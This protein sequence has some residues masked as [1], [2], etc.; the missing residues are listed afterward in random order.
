MMVSPA[1]ARSTALWID[2][3][4]N[5]LIVAAKLIAGRPSRSRARPA[6]TEYFAPIDRIIAPLGFDMPAFLSPQ[7]AVRER[8]VDDI[9]RRCAPSS[10]SQHEY[11][12]DMRSISSN[13]YS[14]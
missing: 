4:G 7:S 1:A 11:P 10:A 2:W 8:D 5:T 6:T 12:A 13:R 14:D 3:P 9:Y